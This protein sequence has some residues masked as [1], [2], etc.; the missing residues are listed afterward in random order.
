MSEPHEDV[1]L[2][3]LEDEAFL[4]NQ[5]GLRKRGNDN[6]FLRWLPKP[7]RAFLKNLSRMKVSELLT[8]DLETLI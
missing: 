5:N 2:G 4:P 1:E 7:I 6:A 3:E 8:R